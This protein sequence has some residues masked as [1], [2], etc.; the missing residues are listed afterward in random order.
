MH[1]VSTC[2]YFTLASPVYFLY[3][4]ANWLQAKN[5]TWRTELIRDPANHRVERKCC[6]NCGAWYMQ[7][8]RYICVSDLY[9]IKSL[10]ALLYIM[11]VHYI[12]GGL[13]IISNTALER[14]L[15]LSTNAPIWEGG[16]SLPDP[17]AVLLRNR[18]NIEW[19]F[20]AGALWFLRP[21]HRYFVR[22]RKS[23]KRQHTRRTIN[24]GQLTTW[25]IDA[26]SFTYSWLL[27]YSYT[28]F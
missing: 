21:W 9:T 10:Y 7:H 18:S 27:L 3:R 15:T 28:L 6:C 12:L 13:C 1:Q 4:H 25:L 22:P 19:W 16:R 24:V 23:S 5:R 17:C 2:H 8:N 26:T 14:P 20:Q 11:Q